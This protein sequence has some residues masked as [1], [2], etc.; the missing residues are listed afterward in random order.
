M[1][2][3]SSFHLLVRSLARSLAFVRLRSFIYSISRPFVIFVLRASN[4]GLCPRSFKKWLFASFSLCFLLFKIQFCSFIKSQKWS[5]FTCWKRIEHEQIRPYPPICKPQLSSLEQNYVFFIGNSGAAGRI[6]RLVWP[7]LFTMVLSS[8]ERNKGD[9]AVCEHRKW[10]DEQMDR[11]TCV[12]DSAT[13]SIPWEWRTLR[14]QDQLDPGAWSSNKMKETCKDDVIA[15]W[16]E[17][18]TIGA[19]ARRS[20]LP[21]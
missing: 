18:V 5:S 17:C 7:N 21:V 8:L 9:D 15:P 4:G 16:I 20:I 1:P 3:F 12:Y 11:R 13:S 10:L 6:W 14:N 19:Q 2:P